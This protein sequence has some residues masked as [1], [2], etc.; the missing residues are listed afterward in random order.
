MYRC[1][2]AAAVAAVV[3]VPASAQVQRA[4]PQAALRG[5]I[6]FAA[7][8]DVLLN[9]QPARLAP[10]ARIFNQQNLLELPAALAGAKVTSH[11]TVDTYG[12]LKDVWL[13]RTDELARKP[14][15]ETAAQAAAWQFDPGAQAWSKP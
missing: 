15:P 14:W 11:Y 13:L 1:A 12:L 8:P 2:L 9:G 7:P 3:A 4:F 6:V 5:V 10:G